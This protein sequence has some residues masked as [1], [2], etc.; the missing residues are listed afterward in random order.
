MIG[1]NLNI[2]N[3]CML[4]LWVMLGAIPLVYGEK[5]L[6]SG[7]GKMMLVFIV[8]FWFVRIFVLQPV[9]VGFSNAESLITAGV[10]LAGAMLFVV[11]LTGYLRQKRVG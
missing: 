1:A 4:V 8:I 11:P 9:Y 6:E 3:W 5:L 10:F 7:P 2:M